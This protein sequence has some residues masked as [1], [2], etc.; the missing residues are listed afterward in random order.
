MN[1]NFLKARIAARTAGVVA[2]SP[3]RAVSKPYEPKR[4]ICEAL[5]SLKTISEKGG[6]NPEDRELIKA[7]IDELKKDLGC[8]NIQ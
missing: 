7:K 1:R 4:E 8:S 5:E 6:V 2:H 3:D